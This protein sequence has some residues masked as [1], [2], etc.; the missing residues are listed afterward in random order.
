MMGKQIIKEANYKSYDYKV[1]KITPSIP[2]NLISILSEVANPWFNGYVVLTKGHNYNGVD[3]DDI[4]VECHRG[5]TFGA[6]D[7][8]DNW[9]I[10]FDCNHFGDN[11]LIHDAYYV[12]LVCKSIIE[13]L[14]ELEHKNK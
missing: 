5:L 3:Y 13:Q 8:N 2:E 7:D 12:E 6:Y 9:V 1:V 11:H 14:I 10:G 4:P